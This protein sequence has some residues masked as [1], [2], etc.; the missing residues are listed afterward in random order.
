[1]KQDCSDDWKWRWVTRH[2][3]EQ[4]PYIYEE[5]KDLLERYWKTYLNVL[6]AVYGEDM[7]QDG[8]SLATLRDSYTLPG[9]CIFPN[10]LL[11]SQIIHFA[12]FFTLPFTS[13]H[14][15]LRCPLRRQT[16]EHK[17]EWSMH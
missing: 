5:F 11:E 17:C 9:A 1:M 4:P 12:S 14:R 2:G 8:L 13:P 3:Y 16:C 15:L 7:G 6:Q 10:S